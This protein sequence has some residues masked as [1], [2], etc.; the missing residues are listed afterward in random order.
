MAEKL[1]QYDPE[2]KTYA[3]MDRG[4][5]VVQ[6]LKTVPM[7]FWDTETTG[8]RRSDKIF[9]HSF[10]GPRGPAWILDIREGGGPVL[11][12]LYGTLG[13]AQITKYAYNAKFDRA[14]VLNE[15]VT[16]RG[17][18]DAFIMAK[19]YP[20]QFRNYKLKEGVAEK[21]GLSVAAKEN[22]DDWFKNKSGTP[23][24]KAQSKTKYIMTIQPGLFTADDDRV[25]KKVKAAKQPRVKKNDIGDNRDYTALPTEL[26]IP[27]AGEDVVLLRDAVALMSQYDYDDVKEL[28]KLE[29]SVQDVILAMER[30]GCR[31]DIGFLKQIQP[32]FRA[33]ASAKLEEFFTCVGISEINDRTFDTRS[34]EAFVDLFYKR[35]RQP[36]IN[37]TN[38]TNKTPST[39]KWALMKMKHP[40]AKLFL[41]FNELDNLAENFIENLISNSDSNG[42]CW[43]QFNQLGARTGRL[44]ANNPNTEN[45]PIQGEG[46]ALRKAFVGREGFDICSID[47]SQIEYRIFASDLGNAGLIQGF[48]D[49]KDY[50]QQTAD[51]MGVDRKTAKSINFGLVYGMGAKALA[52]KLGVGTS[53]GYRY[54]DKYFAAIPEVTKL[55]QKIAGVIADRG[56]IKTLLGHRQ[57]LSIDKAYVGL[58]YRCQGSAANIFKRMMVAINDYLVANALQTRIINLVHDETVLELHRDE[59]HILEDL[60]IICE[61]QAP[62]LKVPLSVDISVGPTWGDMVEIPRQELRQYCEKHRQ[63][64]GATVKKTYTFDCMTCGAVV[65]LDLTDV[66]FDAVVSR[67]GVGGVA[68][69]TNIRGAVT[70]RGCIEKN[71]NDTEL[72]PYVCC[73]ACCGLK[74]TQDLTPEEFTEATKDD[75]GRVLS[76]LCEDCVA[77]GVVI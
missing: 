38:D 22:I 57:Y 20:A 62:E 52:D 54:Y 2:T 44:S 12:Q 68:G 35:L 31:V 58:N 61:A 76:R 14:M 56:Y 21:L 47:Q 63:R 75:E 11:A 64:V 43:P 15:G 23:V 34:P 41:E 7:L 50:H 9:C 17:C 53:E 59:H 19:L 25:V 24:A 71:N 49:G 10:C 48:K 4:E 60:A 32:E 66:E 16:V 30:Q 5:D 26:I 13:Q 72:K 1:Y 39:D 73:C 8:L 18:V 46:G 37:Y 36:I 55:K 3:V 42:W 27:Y 6:A 65:V 67:P 45:I 77:R 28:F 33:R 40:A 29:H 51:L 69:K 70:C 74:F